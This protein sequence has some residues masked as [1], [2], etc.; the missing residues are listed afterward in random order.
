MTLRDGLTAGLVAGLAG[1]IFIQLFLAATQLA[2]GTPA[3]RLLDG[4]VF[5]ASALLGPSAQANPNAIPIGIGLHVLV[6]IGW[7]LGYVYLIRSQ[8]QLLARPWISG[9]GFGFVVYVFMSVVLITAGLYHRPSPGG[10]G[11]GLTSHIVFFGIPVALIVSR[12]LRSRTA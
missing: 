3:G 1:A 8:P 4:F 9:A 2:G 12:L 6:S 11:I 5:T 10:L 7:A